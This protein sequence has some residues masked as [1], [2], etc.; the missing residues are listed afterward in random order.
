M[1]F[2]HQ[3]SSDPVKAPRRVKRRPVIAAGAVVAMALIGAGCGSAANTPTGAA[4]S[5][6]TKASAVSTPSTQ[7]TTT[8]TM[9]PECGAPRD[10]MDPTNAG[11]PNPPGC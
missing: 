5:H 6:G 10:P 9:L 2:S 8:T 4:L 7:A 1:N 11:P 3:R